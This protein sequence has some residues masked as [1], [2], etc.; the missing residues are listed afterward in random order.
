[1]IY[2]KTEDELAYL[3]E[4]G[5][6]IRLIRKSKKISLKE[7]GRRCNIHHTAIC[8]IEY[9]HRSSFILTLRNIADKLEVDVKVFL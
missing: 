3:K 8:E 6:K 9:G 4:M 1:M 5:R 2:K 7:L